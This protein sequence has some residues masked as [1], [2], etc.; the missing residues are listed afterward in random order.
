[1]NNLTSE[2][3]SVEKLQ[4]LFI[5]LVQETITYIYGE[6]QATLNEEDI[7]TIHTYSADSYAVRKG[8]Q[9]MKGKLTTG[10]PRVV[11]NK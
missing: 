1:M 11:Y 10:H 2:A 9:D 3:G 7:I 8:G 6:K 4:T 5:R